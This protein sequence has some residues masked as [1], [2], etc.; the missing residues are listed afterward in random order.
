MDS[1]FGLYTDDLKVFASSE[2]K[3]QKVLTTTQAAMREIGLELNPKKCSIIN[4]KRCKQV[5][6]G[7][8]A[9]LD[10]TTEIASLNE[11]E[12]YKFLGVLENLKQ[13]DKLTSQHESKTY[14]H[15]ISIIW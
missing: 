11:S 9:E 12:P 3:L 14:L 8:K 5:Y 6:D 7:S 4:V 10:D 1:C 13:D 15:R 2:S